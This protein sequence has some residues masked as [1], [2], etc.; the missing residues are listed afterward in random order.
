MFGVGNFVGPAVGGLFAQF[1]SWRLAFVV[2]AVA[3]GVLAVLVR[4]AVPAAVAAAPGGG[5]LPRFRPGS[6]LPWIYLTIALLASGVAVETFLPLFGQRLGGLPPVVAGFLASALSLGW[7]ASQLVSASA[8]EG[9]TVRRLQVAGPALLAAGFAVLALLQHEHLVLVWFPVLLLGGAGVGIA[10]PHLSVAAM[11][12]GQRAGAAIAT[13][14]TMS[15]ALGAVLA[16]LLVNLGSPSTVASARLLLVGF[17]VVAAFG[18]GT[19][20]LASARQLC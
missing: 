4:G 3:A 18:V 11:A 1:G 20:R 2:L 10:M 5:F 9:R 6:P 13:V 17:A 19:A 12:E 8:R 16:G 15:T 7:S 14:L